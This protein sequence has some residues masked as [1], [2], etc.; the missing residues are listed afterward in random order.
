ME[1]DNKK[2]FVGIVSDMTEHKKTDEALVKSEKRYKK[3]GFYKS[4]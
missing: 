2:H 1:L 4:N 3:K